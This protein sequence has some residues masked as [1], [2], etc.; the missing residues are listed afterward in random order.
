MNK[1]LKGFSLAELLISLL[2]ISIVLAA[3]IPTITRKSGAN[4]ENIWRWSSSNNNA[5][6][7]IGSNQTAIIGAETIPF[8]SENGN[9]T[10]K[11]LAEIFGVSV[12]EGDESVDLSNA[13]FT[14]TGDKLVLLKKSHID[15]AGNQ[16]SLA[17]SHI[18][19]F[20]LKN[21]DDATTADIH[22]D[23]RIGLTNHNLAFGIGTLQSMNTTDYD[24]NNTAL[25]HY[26]LVANI[27]G[28]KNTGV[29]E[30]TLSFNK[31]GDNNTS[32][33]FHA[34]F[35]LGNNT[36]T[37]TAN[38]PYYSN[39]TAVGSEALFSNIT[40][41]GNTAIGSLAL[42]GNNGYSNTA[43]GERALIQTTSGNN[44]TAVGQ[45]ACSLLKE[46]NKNIC[47][48]SKAGNGSI[49]AN[50]YKDYYGLYIGSSTE[51][52]QT[53]LSLNDSNYK[54]A[55][56]I[57]GHLQ[58]IKD[59]DTG[60]VTDKELIVNAKNFI[61]RPY[62]ASQ[63]L[64]QFEALSGSDG[65]NHDSAGYMGRQFL[66]LKLNG[67]ETSTLG[68]STSVQD[69]SSCILISAFNEVGAKVTGSDP[70]LNLRNISFNEVLK[71]EFPKV[72]QNN[73][74]KIY[75]TADTMGRKSALELNKKLYIDDVD[76]APTIKIDKQG[77]ALNMPNETAIDF[78]EHGFTTR[79]KFVSFEGPKPVYINTEI[80]DITLN[81]LQSGNKSVSN[82][83][84]QLWEKLYALTATPSDERLKNIKGNNTAGLK[85]ITALEV[86]NFTYK[87]DKEK[88]PH[89]GVIAQQLQKIFPNSVIKDNKG[90]LRIKTEEIFYAMVNS[91]KELCTQIQDLTA[92]ITGLDKRITELEKQNKILQQQNSDFEK[93]L[94]KLE[95]QINK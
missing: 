56:L 87:D 31:I 75:T 4:R 25:G 94:E 71:F 53:E 3:A 20:S 67:S 40:G 90:F 54:D 65:Y 47:I 68:F 14:N 84:D 39:N 69:S 6:F 42:N 83:I 46:G 89:V 9:Q 41:Y 17:N 37:D 86:K 26:S 32:V 49:A 24:G 92:K 81:G 73:P 77:F 45:E 85:E 29:G 8:L 22:Y 16:Y 82:N 23:G 57:E 76:E 50:S 74:V 5:Y 62:D 7:G 78:N 51:S 38:A 55:P 44:N 13:I 66:R 95:K 11:T 48:G 2:I 79:T 72:P 15:E 93:R 19:F 35:N 28:E 70:A 30:K 59:P 61:V 64:Y 63:P 88:T 10:T 58:R 27:T 21:S 34:A 91:I 60:N 1:K 18:S 33:G 52:G 36:D 12:T 43:I 80:G